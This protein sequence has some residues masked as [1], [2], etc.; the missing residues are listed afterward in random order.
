M[1]LTLQKTIDK[2]SF[3]FPYG[4]GG[5][6]NTRAEALAALRLQ[7][8]TPRLNVNYGRADPK[9][10]TKIFKFVTLPSQLNINYPTTLIKND[11]LG[12]DGGIVKASQLG[13]LTIS[14]NGTM[15]ANDEV[16][17]VESFNELKNAQSEKIP[18]RC[19]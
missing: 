1:S 5:R 14:G 17:A 13:F 18:L 10:E 7:G 15:L 8:F 3:Q 19:M 16:S 2:N 12:Q 4:P 6:Y 9:I 11:F